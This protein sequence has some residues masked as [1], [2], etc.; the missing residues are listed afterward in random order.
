M[1]GP[2]SFVAGGAALAV[3][4]AVMAVGD[5]ARY[6]RLLPW[7]KD[8]FARVLALSYTD[9]GANGRGATEVRA[10]GGDSCLVGPTVGFDVDDSYAFDIDERVELTL[11]YV[12]DLTTAEAIVVLFDKNGGDGRGSVE[13][14]P[15]RVG[16]RARATVQLDRARLAGQ[17]AQGVDLAINGRQGAI[18]L[19]T[20]EGDGSLGD[21]LARSPRLTPVCGHRTWLLQPRWSL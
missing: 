1:C 8:R 6:S 4:A 13:I 19:S 7:K 12:P 17:G 16:P 10:V 11:D 20:S 21:L 15:Q 3:A 2:A 14:A 9:L 5:D 18:G